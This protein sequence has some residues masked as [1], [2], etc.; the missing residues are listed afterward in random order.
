MKTFEV[1]CIDEEENF[2]TLSIEAENED[3]AIKSAFWSAPIEE[4]VEICESEDLE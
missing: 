3:W 1:Q 4:V 2:I